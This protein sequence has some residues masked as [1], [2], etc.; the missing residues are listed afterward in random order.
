MQQR[1]LFLQQQ[2][3][4]PREARGSPVPAGAGAATSAS[5]GGRRLRR[6]DGWRAQEDE[7]GLLSPQDPVSSSAQR[8][9]T[10]R[11][12]FRCACSLRQ[13]S[14][15]RILL[16]LFF[17]SRLL[18]TGSVNAAAFYVVPVI[19]HVDTTHIYLHENL[20]FFFACAAS[21]THTQSRSKNNKDPKVYV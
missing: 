12:L 20:S 5:T 3:Q 10:R 4:P 13:V 18:L 2:Q 6:A 14:G 1:L 15:G 7:R 17:P 16:S 21:N 8:A 11:L 9:A 19:L